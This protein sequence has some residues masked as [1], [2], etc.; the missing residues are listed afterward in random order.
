MGVLTRRRPL[1]T[2]IMKYDKHNQSL[3]MSQL[4]CSE[5]QTEDGTGTHYNAYEATLLTDGKFWRNLSATYSK[6]KG[7]QPEVTTLIF[8]W[9]RRGD[10][11]FACKP[12]KLLKASFKKVPFFIPFCTLSAPIFQGLQ[13]LSKFNTIAP[14]CSQP[15]L[16]K[17]RNSRGIMCL[18]NRECW[19]ETESSGG[20]HPETPSEWSPG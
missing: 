3:G 13:R 11:I 1:R 15:E 8:F 10:S 16:H 6:R 9:C 2:C 17:L 7:L 14:L 20:P 19:K 18:I 5:L 4:I 12:L